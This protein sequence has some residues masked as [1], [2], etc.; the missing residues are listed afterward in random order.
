VANLVEADRL[1]ILTDQ[2][3][4]FDADPRNNADANLIREA[5]ASD[6]TIAR[7]AGGG[8]LLGRGGMATKVRAGKLAARSGA[9][10]TIASGRSPEVLIE[11]ADGQGPGTTLL[12]DTSPMNA[13]KQWLAGHLQMRGRL[14]LDAGAVARLRD[15]GSSLLPVGVVDVFGQFSRG[16]MVACEDQQG[17]RIGCGLVNYD[18]ADARRICRKKSA[19]I[20]EVLGFMN[21]EELIHRDNLVVFDAG[22]LTPE[23]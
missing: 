4:L 15:G 23:A 17:E 19:E 9:I 2:E 22:S 7:V 21:E 3:G 8:G 10:T 12:P 11:L 1:L 13:R 6:P 18:A 16:E 20:A 14:V 5:Q